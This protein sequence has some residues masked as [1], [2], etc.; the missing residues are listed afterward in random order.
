M[1]GRDVVVRALGGRAVLDP[2]RGSEGREFTVRRHLD[3][4]YSVWRGNRRLATYDG[5]ARLHGSKNAACPSRK[6]PHDPA[7]K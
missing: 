1:R 5:Q 4:S 7:D 3:Q 6:S 2:G